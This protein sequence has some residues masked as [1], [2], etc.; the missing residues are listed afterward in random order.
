MI[1]PHR[2]DLLTS[3]VLFAN[4]ESLSYKEAMCCLFE[5]ELKIFSSTSLKKNTWGESDN[6]TFEKI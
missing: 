4:R 3:G 2:S 1:N 5:T 6:N